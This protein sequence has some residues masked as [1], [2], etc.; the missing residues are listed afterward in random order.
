[1]TVATLQAGNTLSGVQ[2]CG[3]AGFSLPGVIGS[4]LAATTAPLVANLV[5]HERE[6]HEVAPKNPRGGPT[7]TPVKLDSGA[8]L[9]SEISKHQDRS[10][11]RN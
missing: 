9:E 7:G 4:K 5:E 3:V 2:T 11:M 8:V 10:A 6:I 1:M